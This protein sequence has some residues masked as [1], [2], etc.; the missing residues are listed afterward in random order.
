M[1]C[2][3]SL[4]AVLYLGHWSGSK[5]P[6]STVCCSQWL[7]KPTDLHCLHL[8][9]QAL[10]VYSVYLCPSL[11]QHS[12]YGLDHNKKQ[13]HTSSLHPDIPFMQ[14]SYCASRNHPRRSS[15]LRSSGRLPPA[16]PSSLSELHVLPLGSIL[17]GGGHSPTHLPITCCRWRSTRSS[18]PLSCGWSYT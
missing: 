5:S 2:Y 6:R 11:Y 18:P 15:A 1:L 16:S 8:W 7:K 17:L 3:D 12:R 13:Q 14:L 9:I 10:L 4:N